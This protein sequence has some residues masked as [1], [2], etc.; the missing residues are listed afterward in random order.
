MDRSA[1]CTLCQNRFYRDIASWR[2]YLNTSALSNM[3]RFF[4]L[5]FGLFYAK[6]LCPV[7]FWAFSESAL[8]QMCYFVFVFMHARHTL[9]SLCLCS[10]SHRNTLNQTWALYGPRATSGPLAILYRPAWGNSW[11]KSQ[12]QIGVIRC[13]Q[14]N[15]TAFIVKATALFPDNETT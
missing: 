1:G 15:C 11:F 9:L 8:M 7:F 14:Y 10:N 2:E 6:V 3:Y 12:S 4:I 5:A 13:T